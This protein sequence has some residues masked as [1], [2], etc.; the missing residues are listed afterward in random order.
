MKENTFTRF[1]LQEEILKSIDLL[2][3]KHPTNVQVML[4]EAMLAYQDVVVQ[5]QTGSG[6]T[7]AYT[8]PICQMIDWNE[9]KPQALILAPTRE[10]AMQI[11][12]DVFNIGRFK[13]I[14]VVVLIG[15]TPFS[16]QKK[17]LTQKMHVVVGTPGRVMDHI[18]RGTLDLSNLQFLIIDEA[19]EMLNLGFMPQLD[20]IVNTLKKNRQTVML[21]A[22]MPERLE[23]L[24]GNYCHQ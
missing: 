15:Q 3:Y 7:A 6:K 16:Y 13:R 12:E 24:I 8:I 10:L 20:D 2:N 17:Q 18:Q 19:D 23:S 4:I 5:S 11:R 22:T 14:K 21:S 1:G 9:N